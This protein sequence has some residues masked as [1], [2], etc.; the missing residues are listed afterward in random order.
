M[1]PL[2]QKLFQATMQ[3]EE[4]VLPIFVHN[5]N[6]TGSKIVAAV[7]VAESVFGS[8]FGLSQPAQNQLPLTSQAPVSQAS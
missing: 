5:P 4:N 2:F 6:S 1:N 7:V 8:I 3:T